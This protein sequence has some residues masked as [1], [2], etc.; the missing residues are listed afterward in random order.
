MN[1]LSKATSGR[2][3]SAVMTSA[4]AQTSY[5]GKAIRLIVPTPLVGPAMR[6]PALSPGA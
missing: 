3:R 1:L 4:G 2:R 6:Q 5:P